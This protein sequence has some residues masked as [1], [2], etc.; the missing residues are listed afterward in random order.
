V[1]KLPEPGEVFALEVSKGVDVLLRVVASVGKSRCVVVTKAEDLFSVQPMAHHGWKRPMIG[2]WVMEPPPPE[3]RAQGL[4]PLRAGEA[5]RVLHPETW[6]KLAKKTAALSHRVLPL[7]AW[8][9]LVNDATAAWPRPPG[10]WWR[11]SP[12]VGRSRSSPT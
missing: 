8:G 7:C 1:S 2:G 12:R 11:A 4:V 9:L 10:T 6:V 5:E 3:L